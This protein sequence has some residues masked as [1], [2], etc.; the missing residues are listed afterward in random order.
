MDYIG[1]LWIKEGQN[2]K[3]MSG[4]VEINGVK[5]PILVFKNTKKEK[6]NQPDYKICQPAKESGL[7]QAPEPANDD[8]KEALDSAYA[9]F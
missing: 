1:A 3:F 4:N 7:Q 2:G 8:N 9:N 5:H 6:D